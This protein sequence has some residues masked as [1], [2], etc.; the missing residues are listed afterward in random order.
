MS[1][2]R[3]VTAFAAALALLCA[4][5]GDDDGPSG[6]PTAQLQTEP[7]LT[8]SIDAAARSLVL[9]RGA[10]ILLT[11]PADGLQLGTV[12]ALDD[13]LSYDPSFLV[14]RD[15]AP[16][17]PPASLRWR[18]L[19]SLVIGDA[20]ATEA[21]LA[22]KFEGGFAASLVLA[23]PAATPGRIA[24][25]LTIGNPRAGGT[26]VAYTRLRARA[27][28]SEG[29]YGLGE[30]PDSVNHRGKLRAMQMQADTTL[31]GASDENHAPVPL[32]IGTRGWGLFVESRRVG[33][34]DVARAEPDLIE[35]TYGTGAAS[36]E[37]F[38][39]H[40]LGATRAVDITALYHGITGRPRLPATWAYGPWIWRDESR[41]Q[42]EVLDD[43]RQIRDLDLATSAI[44]LDRPYASGVNSFDFAP[45]QFPDPP[46]M[47]AAAHA[48]GLRVALWHTPYLGT[49]A[50]ALRDEASSKGF[51]PPGSGVLLNNWGKPIDF[52]NPAAYAWW[53]DLIRRYTSMGIEG[54]KL[55]YAEDVLAGL[56]GNRNPW[57]FADGS[58]E[59]TMHHGYT[60][61]YH[62]VYA[63]TLPATGGFLL[64][65]AARWGDQ[66]NVSVIWPGDMDATFTRHR[67]SFDKPGGGRV[68]GVGGLPATVIQGMSLS[69]SGFPF[70]GADTGGYRHSPPGKEL[71]IRW[72]E[73]TALS[74][75]MQVGDSSSQPPW[76]FT[77]A[78]G[79]DQAT[80]DL[81]RVFARLHL[82]LFPYVWTYAE[83]VGAGGGSIQ[84]P[85][86]LVYPEV[87]HPDD[88]YLMGDD[89]LVAP[90][91]TAG[92]TTRTLPL[93]AGEWFD[94]WDGTP[95][96]GGA[97]G[98][99]VT[100][101]A[102][103]E[104]LPLLVRAGAIVPLLRPDIDTLSTT[105]AVG[106]ESYA[107]EPGELWVRVWPGPARTFTL[108]DGARVA[109]QADGRVVQ[110]M[111]GTKFAV[112]MRLVLERVARPAGVSVEGVAVAEAADLEAVA[113]GWAMVSGVLH[114]KLVA[115]ARRVEL[116]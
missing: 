89:L 98:A 8:V 104:R 70:F 100:V 13:R 14:P 34:F 2:R 78:N 115:A 99:M 23:A 7:G 30:W 60:V 4:G 96:S 81:Y 42:A 94:W 76:L 31:E 83:A 18:A 107:D 103:L 64:G 55:D 52:T 9:A 113:Q 92:A 61:L 53:Q 108:F 72:F 67:E 54:F 40:L 69:A 26:S 17:N 79:R 68:V 86:G 16:A 33:A 21:T 110:V 47:I 46:A 111:P 63:E 35:V 101:P 20:S 24:A 73:Q 116:Q 88:V 12:T 75:V 56:G 77:A 80:L 32:L 5:C 41:D 10:G 3:L 25:T 28:A 102:P 82:R 66:V 1:G 95:Q 15:G 74:T 37:P 112:G 62:K 85:L 59:R 71:Y 44:W 91:V 97:G 84:R 49:D 106:V 51:F 39:F 109:T 93:P 29:F 45:A 65:R 87:G 58:D 22:L 90:V 105:T 27:S 114:I 57:R 50:G 19:T 6:P 11:L 36:G 38:R 48:A 43:I